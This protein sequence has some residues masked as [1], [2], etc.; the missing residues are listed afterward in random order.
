MQH[1]GTQGSAFTCHVAC[2]TCLGCAD[3]GEDAACFESILSEQPA[4]ME[5]CNPFLAA[6]GACQAGR[7]AGACRGGTKHQSEPLVN[8][9]V[10]PSL[11][12]NNTIILTTAELPRAPAYGPTSQLTY[13][14]DKAQLLVLHIDGSPLGLEVTQQL[15]T[16]ILRHGG[17]LRLARL[18][19]GRVATCRQGVGQ[20]A[21]H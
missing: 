14:H 15:L 4:V 2:A 9:S 8:S 16:L 7:L 21:E 10:A 3:S 13:V 11:L 5:A 18:V 17:G 6:P 1:R 19:T 12:I 20:L